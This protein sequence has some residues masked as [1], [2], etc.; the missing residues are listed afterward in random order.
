[1]VAWI[2]GIVPQFHILAKASKEDLSTLSLNGDILFLIL[3]KY[4]LLD[5]VAQMIAFYLLI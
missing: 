3:Q 1:L 4:V 2:N 5:E